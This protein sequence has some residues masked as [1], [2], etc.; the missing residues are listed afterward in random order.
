MVSQL[1]SWTGGGAINFAKI[2]TAATIGGLALLYGFDDL[3]KV[4]LCATKA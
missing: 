1:T 3:R 2:F 4:S